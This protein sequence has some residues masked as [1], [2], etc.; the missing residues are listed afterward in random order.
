MDH[1]VREAAA[2][3]QLEAASRG[4][5]LGVQIQHHLPQSLRS[6][7]HQLGA[8]TGSI[9]VLQ[10]L[11]ADDLAVVTSSAVALQLFMRHLEA[12]CQRW[13]LVISGS[14]TECMLLDPRQQQPEAWWRAS[15]RC[16]CCHS[17]AE[18]PP[19]LVCSCC[20]S[21]WHTTCLQPPLDEVP[22]DDWLCPACT[23]AAA[24]SD[25]ASVSRSKPVRITVA[26]QP[27][28][29]VSHFKYLGSQ[30]SSDGS[31]DAEVS[32]RISQAAGAFKRL[33][34]PVWRHGCIQLPT[35]L[36]IYRA[37]VS[38][39]LLYAAHSWALT[40]AQL[41]RLE[42]AQRAQ[43][44]RMVG[45]LSW[46]VP[47]GGSEPPRTISNASLHRLCQ[48]PTIK[49]QLHRTRGCWV[50]HILRMPDHRLAKQLFFGTL[51][52]S[53]PPQSRAPPSLLPLYHRDV[54]TRYPSAVLRKYDSNL[55]TAAASKSDWNNHFPKGS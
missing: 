1:V 16:Q 42:V 20:D 37:M 2:A 24:A 3:A 14:K 31:L 49:E 6:L 28:T 19:M 21:G 4:I 36:R 41:E 38:S 27:V 13:G 39:V 9:E 46:K 11:L 25:G 48:Q 10:L 34:K 30:F 23:A 53:A 43:L 54:S 26:G 52:T 5:Q 44:R 40:D 45:S 32:H 55:L 17:L 51:T 33:H 22:A 35:K 29:W 47:P 50:G 7:N 15:I 8:S 18:Q 12:A